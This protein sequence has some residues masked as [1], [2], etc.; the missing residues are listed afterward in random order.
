MTTTGKRS[1]QVSRSPEE[2]RQTLQR[3]ISEKAFL[4][5]LRD[6]AHAFGWLTYHTH[7]SRRSEHGFPDLALLHTKT[8]R[9]I[10]AELKVGKNKPSRAQVIWLDGI[11]AAGVD[12]YLW[13]PEDWP[14]I[15]RI[16]RG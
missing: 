5:Q 7:D 4:Q 14:E 1:M 2:S 9:L 6:M 13:T 12:A 10:F 8:F 11:N 3:Q 16:L 15:E